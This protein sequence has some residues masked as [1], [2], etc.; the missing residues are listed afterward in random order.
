MA[1]LEIQELRKSY[2]REEVVKGLSMV[3]ERGQI[4]G[5]LGPNGSGKTTTLSCVLGLQAASAGQVRVLGE[6]PPHL[7]RLKGRLGVVF[8]RAITLPGLTVLDNL[9]YLR[10]LLG[11][12]R[13]RQAGLV[14]DLVELGA[15]AKQRVNA[16]SLGQQKRLAIAGALLGE[17]EL[18]VLDEPLS[19]LD[20]MGVGR[21]LRLFGDLKEQGVTLVLSSHRLHEMETVITHAGILHNGV[22]ERGGALEDLL[23]T[24]RSQL[25][26][27]VSDAGRVRSLLAST[28]QV[29]V[30]LEADLGEG[31]ALFTLR[32]DGLC[33]AQLNHDLVQQG[34]RVSRLEEKRSSLLRVFEEV[35]EQPLD[36]GESP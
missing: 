17:P 29:E 36:P 10:H 35:V 1:A 18:L 2:G 28:P 21:M 31:E 15:M 26:L 5:L 23:A 30:E 3:V 20:T 6:D 25:L 27:G 34:V 24:S 16:L 32:L 33:A 14:L 7:H 11:H 9:K 13:G 22:I 12:G 19:G 8:D 4:Y